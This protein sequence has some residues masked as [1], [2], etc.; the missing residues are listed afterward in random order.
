MKLVRAAIQPCSRNRDTI[1]RIHGPV[2]SPGVADGSGFV[3]LHGTRVERLATFLHYAPLLPTK[4]EKG[5]RKKGAKRVNFSGDRRAQRGEA[6]V[7]CI[8]PP[9]H[10]P[11]GTSLPP[12]TKV[13]RGDQIGRF[14]HLLTFSLSLQHTDPRRS[15]I[16]TFSLIFTSR[17]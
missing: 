7:N 2:K 15:T 14:L 17:V 4:R 10:C 12:S 6:K 3:F 11:R 5:Q 8:F 16:F 9:L 13:R 1:L